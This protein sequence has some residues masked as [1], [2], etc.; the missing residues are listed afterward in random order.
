M[1]KKKKKQIGLGMSDPSVLGKLLEQL[2]AQTTALASNASTAT[3]RASETAAAS[4]DACLDTL[5][6]GPDALQQALSQA[7]AG[8]G[9]D[10]AFPDVLVATGV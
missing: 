3:L 1:A 9:H 10:D 7:R 2:Q 4:L 5:G 6:G 8:T